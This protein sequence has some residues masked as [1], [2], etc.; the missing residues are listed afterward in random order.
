MSTATTSTSD[1]VDLPSSLAAF[2]REALGF[3]AEVGD[4]VRALDIRLNASLASLT[5]DASP[6]GI[7][8]L[9]AA[10]VVDGGRDASPRAAPEPSPPSPPPPPPPPPSFAAI[11]FAYE[12]RRLRDPPRALRVRLAKLV[13]D[14]DAAVRSLADV[15]MARFGDHAE[16]VLDAVQDPEA[17]VQD[18]PLALMHAAE[19]VGAVESCFEVLGPAMAAALSLRA[20]FDAW[21][22]AQAQHLAA[23]LRPALCQQPLASDEA[24]WRK[25]HPHPPDAR[26]VM[27]VGVRAHCDAVAERCEG[28]RL[29]PTVAAALS[30]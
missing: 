6:D 20:S 10:T 17:Y 8:A 1:A 4:R 21:A 24:L 25:P 2:C 14:D 28:V 23:R 16:A 26:A 3:A 9:R 12:V 15:V 13:Q 11:D 27:L 5:D 29:W 7:A 22:D 19:V 18:V 30:A